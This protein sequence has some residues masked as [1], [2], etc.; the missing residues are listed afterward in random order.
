M[1]NTQWY[2]TWILGNQPVWLLGKET[3][4]SISLIRSELN[5]AIPCNA[6]ASGY[7]VNALAALLMHRDTLLMCWLHC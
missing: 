1:S 2:P 5:L 6:N 7:I 4:Y 3:K